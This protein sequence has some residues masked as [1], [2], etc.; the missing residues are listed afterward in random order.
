MKS[1]TLEQIK[2]SDAIAKLDR[3][4]QKAIIGGADQTAYTGDK[5]KPVTGSL[6]RMDCVE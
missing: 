1:R 2:M 6:F 5:D 3:N 4:A